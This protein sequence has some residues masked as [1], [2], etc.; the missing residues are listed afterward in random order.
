MVTP[1]LAR[2]FASIGVDLIPI[3]VGARMLVA[4]IAGPQTDQVEVFLGGG[5]LAPVEPAA[6]QVGV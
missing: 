2:H 6:H 3:D 5:V 1:E 4:E